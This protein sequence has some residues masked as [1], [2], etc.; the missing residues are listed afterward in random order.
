MVAACGTVAFLLGLAML[1]FN[2]FASFNP[3]MRAD[4]LAFLGCTALAGL[5]YPQWKIRIVTALI[6]SGCVYAAIKDYRRA[7]A[8]QQWLEQRRAAQSVQP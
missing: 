2:P 4:G 5:L 7:D 8:H 6:A 3:R 1:F